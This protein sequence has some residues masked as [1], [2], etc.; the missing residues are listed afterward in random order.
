MRLEP[1]AFTKISAL[2]V[3]EQRVNVVGSLRATP[4]SLGAEYRIDVA[5]VVWEGDGVLAVPASAVFQRNNR[6]QAFVNE[7]GRARLR[8]LTVGRRNRDYVQVLGGVA[9]GDQVI[10]FPSDLVSDGVRVKA[11]SPGAFQ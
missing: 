2:G 5:I 4:A 6:W 8:E 1:Q 11:E 3:E 7:D 10:L 9:A